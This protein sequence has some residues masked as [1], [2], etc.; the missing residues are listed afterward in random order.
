[1]RERKAQAAPSLVASSQRRVRVYSC[2]ARYHW[3]A[4]SCSSFISLA[5]RA[6]ALQSVAVCGEFVCSGELNEERAIQMCA[7]VCKTCTEI[8]T[9]CSVVNVFNIKCQTD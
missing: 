2:T 5:L 3:L 4:G 1:M 7:I 6:A 9:E 8:S